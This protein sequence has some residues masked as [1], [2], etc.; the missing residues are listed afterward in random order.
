MSKKRDL[1]GWVP[2]ANVCNSS[3]SGGKNQVDCGSKSAQ[4]N[5]FWDF[6][7]KKTHPK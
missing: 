1:K 6:I 7:L 5:S 4:E 2:V 3:Y